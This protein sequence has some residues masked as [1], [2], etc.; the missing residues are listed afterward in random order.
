MQDENAINAKGKMMH[1]IR[2]NRI[3]KTSNALND[4]RDL[5]EIFILNVNES[6]PPVT[7]INYRVKNIN[8]ST[9]IISNLFL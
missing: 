7:V 9:G 5:T 3:W 2:Q 6:V 4:K 1:W 8:E